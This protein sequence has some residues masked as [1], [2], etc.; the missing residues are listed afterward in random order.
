MYITK[1][2]NK[3][4]IVIDEEKIKVGDKIKWNDM[5]GKTVYVNEDCIRVILDNARNYC[6]LTARELENL[7]IEKVESK[8]SKFATGQLYRVEDTISCDKFDVLIMTVSDREISAL[9]IRSASAMSIK[10]N[11]IDSRYKFTKIKTVIDDNKT[12]KEKQIDEIAD[13]LGDLK[14]ANED[15]F[16]NYAKWI[17]GNQYLNRKCK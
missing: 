11:E 14:E 6:T 12:G 2:I 10:K 5:S 17:M 15:L 3:P 7:T 16:Y 1:Q 4:T 9:K 8:T 13:A